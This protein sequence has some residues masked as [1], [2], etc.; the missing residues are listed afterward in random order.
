MNFSYIQGLFKDSGIIFKLKQDSL[1]GQKT[2]YLLFLCF[3][4]FFLPI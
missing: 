2:G 1:Q 3:L 4:F